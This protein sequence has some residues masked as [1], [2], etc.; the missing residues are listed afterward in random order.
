ML[1]S[2]GKMCSQVGIVTTTTITTTETNTNTMHPALQSNELFNGRLCMLGFFAAV[3]QQFR[4]GGLHGPGPIA[5]VRH[6]GNAY[7]G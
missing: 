5:Q 3:V 1:V 2:C 6:A 7:L 4:M